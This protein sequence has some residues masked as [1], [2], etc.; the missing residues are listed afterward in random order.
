M[1]KKINATIDLITASSVDVHLDVKPEYKIVTLIM[2]ADDKEI[3]MDRLIL[4]SNEGIKKIIMKKKDTE[5]S[6]SANFINISYL[7]Y[8]DFR[9]EFYNKGK[10][11]AQSNSFKIE[12]KGKKNLY[13][14]VNKML[15]DFNKLWIVSGETCTL[16]KEN[17]VAQKCEYC[18]DFDLDQRISTDCP[19]CEGG[20]VNEFIGFDFKARKIKTQTN[21]IV[22]AKGV[23]IINLMLYVTFS[24]FNFVLGDIFFDNATRNFFEI[25]NAVP[26]SV[27]GVR[28]STSL[29]A[30]L[31][32]INDDRVKKLIPYLN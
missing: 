30:Q 29:T 11:V 12:P 27:G 6:L 28:T 20:I 1:I 17:P 15:F 2:L 14:I 8:K 22:A 10:I 7:F 16:F 18:W 24:R 25:K 19:H 3:E 26:A 13:G 4:P 32:D 21:Q 23:E 9:L 5:W 31:I